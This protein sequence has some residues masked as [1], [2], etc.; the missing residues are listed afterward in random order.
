V[1]PA[2][3][4]RGSRPKA[5]DGRRFAGFIVVSLLACRASLKRGSPPLSAAPER[6]RKV[7]SDNRKLSFTASETIVAPG[8]YW[9]RGQLSKNAEKVA[10]A[11]QYVDVPDVA[12]D[13]AE[14]SFDMGEISL[15]SEISGLISRSQLNAIEALAG[16]GDAGVTD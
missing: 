12:A 9:V 3:C 16:V 11:D 15:D 14:T 6:P 4:S 1:A 8:K 5:E 13:A 10:K 7:Q 2:A